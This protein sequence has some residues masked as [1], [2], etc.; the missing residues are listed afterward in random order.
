MTS[1]LIR[2][3]L[4]GRHCSLSL[5]IPLFNEEQVFPQ[6]RDRLVAALEQLPDRTEI[7]FVN[8]GSTDRTKELVEQ[9]ASE[10]DR[11]IGVHFS[12][13]FGHQQAVSAGLQTASGDAVAVLDGDLQ[14]PPEVLPQFLDKLNEGW[15]VVYAIREQRKEGLLKRA[16]YGGFYRLLAML[17]PIHIPLDS[18]DFGMISRR[19]VDQLNSMPE[20]HRFIRG[21]RSY[22]GFRQTG[23]AYERDARADGVSKYSWRKLMG[24]AADGIFTFSALPLRLASFAGF[25][26]AGLAFLYAIYV[27]IW[28]FVSGEGSE[29]DGFAALA[30]GV[31]F[32]GGIQLICLGILGEYVG[33]IHNEVKQRPSYVVES[34]SMQNER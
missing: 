30:V 22:V 34:I 6:M 29:I 1:E 32:L 4:A 12:R 27:L 13:N 28:K 26:I 2:N 19:V 20:Q 33:R 3:S 31:F 9:A 23:L 18:G 8:D 11:I 16:C 14:D 21:M 7:I 25:L 10:D 15:D 17:T 5:V 24:L